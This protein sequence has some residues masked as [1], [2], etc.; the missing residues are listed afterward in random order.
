[1]VDPPDLE[2]EAV[3]AK[4]DGGEAGGCRHVGCEGNW[5]LMVAI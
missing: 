4:V 1:V 2:P 3:G 5:A